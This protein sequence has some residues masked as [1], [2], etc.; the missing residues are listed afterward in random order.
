MISN[1]FIKRVF[2]ISKFQENY[3]TTIFK[4]KM[5]FLCS[6]ASLTWDGL[7]Y[8]LINFS[9]K[10]LSKGISTECY[11]ISDFLCKVKCGYSDCGSVSVFLVK[12]QK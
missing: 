10:I 6:Q 4:S 9:G 3:S 7:S 5:P 1:R 8:P 2:K 12:L 11:Q